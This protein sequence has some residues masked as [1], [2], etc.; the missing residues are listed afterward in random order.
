[1]VVGTG[2]KTELMRFVYVSTV[3]KMYIVAHAPVEW[4]RF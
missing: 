2:G 4:N 3:E 1:M